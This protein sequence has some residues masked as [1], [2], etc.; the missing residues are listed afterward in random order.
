MHP[1]HT[2]NV[3]HQHFQHVHYYPQTQSAV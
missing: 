1:Q 2:T 3:N